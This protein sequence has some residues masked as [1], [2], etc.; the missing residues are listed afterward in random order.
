VFPS[1]GDAE[2]QQWQRSKNVE[3]NSQ[4]SGYMEDLT[5]LQRWLHDTTMAGMSS[6]VWVDRSN[7][8][9]GYEIWD[10]GFYLVD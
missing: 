9:Y 2:T 10:G 5:K 4:L 1:I 7:R 6:G 3:F 8:G